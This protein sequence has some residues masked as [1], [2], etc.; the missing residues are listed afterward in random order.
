MALLATRTRLEDA[1]SIYSKFGFQTEN[2]NESSVFQM[3]LHNKKALHWKRYIGPLDL[4]IYG[5]YGNMH[6]LGSL[7]CDHNN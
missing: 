5:L 4:W 1:G 6:K 3:A 7:R 2:L